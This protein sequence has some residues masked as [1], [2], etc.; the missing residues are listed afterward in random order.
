MAGNGHRDGHHHS[1]RDLLRQGSDEGIRAL[2]V[3]VVGLFITAAVQFAV[4]AISGSVALLADAL[5]NLGDVLT[6]AALWLGL[7]ATRRAADHRYSF[8]Y[9][10]F[11][12]LAGLGVVLA[13]FASAAL[14]GYE[15]VLRLVQGGAP[16]HLIAGMCAG[17]AG[18]LG[19]EAVAQY[20]VRVGNRINS[21][22]L[23]AEGQHSRVDG[24]ASLA[25][26]AGLAGVAAGADWADPV[27]GLALV[28]VIVYLGVDAGRPIVATLLDK[29]E[30]EMLH[31]IEEVARSV[32]HV[33]DVHDVRARWAG[34]ALYVLLH[35]SLPS[36][37]SLEE[38]HEAGEEVRHAV[39]HELPEAVQVDVHADPGGEQA[40]YHE[41]T[42]HHFQSHA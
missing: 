38:A 36:E 27:A 5:H 13:I 37:M 41:T 4:L 2:K 35:V 11:E 14:A 16:T 23:V 7:I 3:S 12:D 8:G 9:Q 29:V 24:F 21:Q 22:A 10:R 28:L 25:V 1:A 31:R 32:E 39:L 42:A 33:T 18:F 26:I 40:A 15:S 30:P 6:S 19:N 17:A 34:R 20:K